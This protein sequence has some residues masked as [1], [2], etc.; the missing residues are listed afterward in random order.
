MHN[1]EYR[2]LVKIKENTKFSQKTLLTPPLPM[3]KCY[4]QHPS[5][6]VAFLPSRPRTTLN[7]IKPATESP[8]P[9]TIAFLRQ[10]AR[11]FYNTG[12]AHSGIVLN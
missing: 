6:G 7:R 4:T 9:E 3:E 2:E 1:K 12:I 10:F 5:F 11:A 8:K